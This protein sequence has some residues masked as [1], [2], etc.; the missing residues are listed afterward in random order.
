MPDE[1][2]RV[3]LVGEQTFEYDDQFY[4]ETGNTTHKV[5]ATRE[6]ADKAAV[7]AN[8]KAMRMICPSNYSHCY[9]KNENSDVYDF[10]KFTREEVVAK[11]V[12][13]F[14]LKRLSPSYAYEWNKQVI[15]EEDSADSKLHAF[16]LPKDMTVEE[17]RQISPLLQLQFFSVFEMPVS[18]YE[19]PK[20]D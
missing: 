15:R 16:M 17:F 14:G 11:L 10:G 9:G 1:L 20:N 7:D 5:F 8:A 3:Y 2:K 4:N 19:E 18:T 6:E 12:E 13:V